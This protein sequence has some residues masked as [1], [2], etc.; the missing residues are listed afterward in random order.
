M[1][2]TKEEMAKALLDKAISQAELVYYRD[3]KRGD[4]DDAITIL[5]QLRGLEMVKKQIRIVIEN[6]AREA[7][8]GKPKRANTSK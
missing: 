7:K 2:T 1:R 8:D 5:T 3:L 4:L 6:E